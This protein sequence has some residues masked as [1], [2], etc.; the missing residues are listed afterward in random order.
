MPFLPSEN[1][2]LSDDTWHVTDC[3]THIQQK[4]LANELKNGCHTLNIPGCSC[5]LPMQAR[6]EHTRR[7]H[8]PATS[9]VSLVKADKPHVST[10]HLHT[11][12]DVHNPFLELP[13]GA[14]DVPAIVGLGQKHANHDNNCRQLAAAEP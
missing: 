14:I 5:D 8:P 1:C 6:A 4:T 10:L 7:L 11:G 12:P 3:C 13:S 2:L 9:I